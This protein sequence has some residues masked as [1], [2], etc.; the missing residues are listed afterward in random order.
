MQSKL[1]NFFKRFVLK[2][3]VSLL[4]VVALVVAMMP[5]MTASGAVFSYNDDGIVTVTSNLGSY[6]YRLPLDAAGNDVDISS[7][8]SNFAYGYGYGYNSS[9]ATYS[10]GYGYG[11][12]YGYFAQTGTSWTAGDPGLGF[13]MGTGGAS[14]SVTLPV[15]AGGVATVA[16]ATT[17]TTSGLAGV[18]VLLPADLVITGAAGWDGSLTSTGTST[19]ASVPT[20]IQS[21][22]DSGSTIAS[23]TISTGLS[24]RVTLSDEVIVKIPFTGTPGL[25]KI[26]DGA[27]TVTT[28]SACSATQYTGATTSDSALTDSDNYSLAAAGV[29]YVVGTGAAAGNTYV[30]TRHLS[31][32]AAGTAATS[33]TT[34]T[35]SGGGGAVVA[36]KKLSKGATKI[37]VTDQEDEDDDDD[38]KEEGDDSYEIEDPV[39]ISELTDMASIPTTDWR[40]TVADRVLKAGLFKGETVN[41]KMVFNGQNGMNRAMAAVVI[42]RYVGCDTAGLSGNP[43]PDVPAS[44]WYGSAVGA[45]KKMGI[46]KGKSNGNFDPG[47]QVTRAEFFKMLVEAYMYNNSDV[48]ASWQALIASAASAFIDVKSTDWFGGYFNLGYEMKLIS[49]YEVAGGKREVRGNNFV[50]RFEAAAMLTNFLDNVE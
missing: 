15:T 20:T 44:E 16:V 33:T 18:S 11:Y 23:V 42:C 29:C 49:G 41:G 1:N 3:L 12:G 25:V 45:L 13:F 35:T 43:F 47:S 37:A 38:D 36:T 32:V 50:S 19:Y 26:V 34:T 40:Y 8:S 46:V 39:L 28:I 4:A 2:N 5:P 22:F 21:A 48:K 10:Y 17:L 7:T 24:V 9:T 14:T 6:F 27:G 30:A 31:T